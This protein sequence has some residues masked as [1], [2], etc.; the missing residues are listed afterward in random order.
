[1]GFVVSIVLGFGVQ[2]RFG[3]WGFQPW[4]VGSKPTI[5]LERINRDLMKIKTVPV[6]IGSACRAL[7][8]SGLVGRGFGCLV[9]GLGFKT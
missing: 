4:A 3:I 1:M 9:Q 8:A 2:F 7:Q 5:L 6:V